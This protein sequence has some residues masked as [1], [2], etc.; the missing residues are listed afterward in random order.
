MCKYLCLPTVRSL[1]NWLQS[2]DVSCGVNSNVLDVVKIKFKDVPTS[3]KLI[4]IIMDEMS[5]KKLISYNSQN[6][7]FSGYEDFGTDHEFVD[8]TMNRICDQV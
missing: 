7:Q 6:D 8:M 4:S 1:R 2:I 5:L 3:E